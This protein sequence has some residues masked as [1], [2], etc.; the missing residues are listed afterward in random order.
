VHAQRVSDCVRAVHAR[1]CLTTCAYTEIVRLGVR[2]VRVRVCMCLC[3]HVCMHVCVRAGTVADQPVP[4]CGACVCVCACVHVCMHVHVRVRA[5]TVADQPVLACVQRA[6]SL[7]HVCVC[8]TCLC[9]SVDGPPG[10]HMLAG[11]HNAAP[12]FAQ[13]CA[14]P[15]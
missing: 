8:S 13:A 2:A 6:L 3:M 5:G 9:V 1:L 14:H 15:L 4:A 12:T 10:A 7:K 11:L